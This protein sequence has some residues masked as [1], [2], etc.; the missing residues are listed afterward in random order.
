[1]L[2]GDVA[3]AGTA[4]HSTAALKLAVVPAVAAVVEEGVAAVCCVE[5]EWECRA[6][7]D[8]TA[9]RE[10]KAG[11]SSFKLSY[12]SCVFWFCRLCPAVQ[13]DNERLQQQLLQQEQR[14][15]ALQQQQLVQQQ[16]HA[17]ASSHMQHQQP[18]DMQPQ[19]QPQPQLAGQGQEQQVQEQQPRVLQLPVSMPAHSDA[20]IMPTPDAG[21]PAAAME[22]AAEAPH[23]APAAADAAAGVQEQGIAAS[24]GADSVAGVYGG[25]DNRSVT[26]AAMYSPTGVQQQTT[27][28]S[29]HSYVGSSAVGAGAA[30]ANGALPAPQWEDIVSTASSSKGSRGW[31][32]VFGGGRKQPQRSALM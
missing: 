26:P 27:P 20:T 25:V 6:R 23:V 13:A 9:G 24:A 12:L 19:L 7:I 2:R 14:V 5:Q 16:Q 8:A 18:V 17:T 1:M 3:V 32:G 10:W 15:L 30:A 22:V 29:A 11:T 31:F 21:A 4:Q 28:P